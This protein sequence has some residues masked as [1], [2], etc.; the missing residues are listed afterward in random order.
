METVEQTDK[1]TGEVKQVNVACVYVRVG[2]TAERK[3]VSILAQGEDF[4]LVEPL[5]SEDATENQQRK[6]LRAGDEVILARGEIWD[7]KVLD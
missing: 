2:V 7:G 3:P 6:V 5:L 1:E 4:Y